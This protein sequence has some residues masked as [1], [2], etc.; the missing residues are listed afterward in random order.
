MPS[1]KE[2]IQWA[3]SLAE[4]APDPY[5]QL[6]FA[7]L[8][9]FG[10][11]SKFE[12]MQFAESSPAPKQR[13]EKEVSTTAN[14]DAVAQF[15]AELNIS[16]EL[17]LTAFGLT[18]EAPFIYLDPHSWEAF[19]KAIPA[20]GKNAI[21]DIAIAATILTLWKRQSALGKTTTSEAGEV[22]KQIGASDRN[23]TRGITH[24]EWLQVRGS[25]VLL[26]PANISMAVEMTKAF[27][28]KRAPKA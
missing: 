23:P 15:A 12:S 27:A 2:I 8:L 14:A 20:R 5:K 19:K 6:A 7:E 3:S 10:L 11:H 22:L 9:K 13:N 18:Q 1:A 21:A 24:C 28:E 4:T 17:A 25:E 26:S 16:P